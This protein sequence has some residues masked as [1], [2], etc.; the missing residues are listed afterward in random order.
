MKIVNTMRNK[1][2]ILFLLVSALPILFNWFVLIAVQ[3]ENHL[4]MAEELLED[5]IS[6]NLKLVEAQTGTSADRSTAEEALRSVKELLWVRDAWAVPGS[7]ASD[8]GDD[9]TVSV[10]GRAGTV[11]L[12]LDPEELIQYLGLEKGTIELIRT[13]DSLD[14]VLEQ[15]R[16]RDSS[17][18]FAG[19]GAFGGA[20]TA[21]VG[22]PK[23]G[24]LEKDRF[25]SELLVRSSLIMMILA[26]SF[27]YIISYR[28]TEGMELLA[29][30]IKRIRKG[31]FSDM[32]TIKGNDEIAD[33]SHAFHSMAGEMDILVNRT[34]RLTIS[35]RNA[36]I[37][38]MQSQIS[39]HFLYNALDCVNWNLLKKG[40]FESSQ[41]LVSLSSILRY[42]IDDTKST[43]TV[44]EEFEQV[45]N[46]LI[47]QQS[48]FSDRFSYHVYLDGAIAEEQ[49]P[50][51]ILQPLVENA[52]SHGLEDGKDGMLRIRGVPVPDG[53][54]ITVWDDG[55]GIDRKTLGLLRDRM[56]G[57]GQIADEQD[58]HLGIANVHNRLRYRYGEGSGLTIESVEGDH[59]LVTIRINT[60]QVPA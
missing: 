39:P 16:A 32:S 24:V 25:W 19:A 6:S 15:R 54:E 43:V 47:V 30:D 55:K 23:E 52:V 46:Y 12:D 41:L 17:R 2:L 35:E 49:V 60:G 28:Y 37:R 13:K 3:P 26:V 59:T 31:D 29:E 42:S 9:L 20:V 7:K 48:R 4:H 56:N 36:K 58:F 45:E 18:V 11:Y 38:A 22:V 14:K 51:M 5:K 8:G 10:T 50:K 40:D 53:I 44:R 57:S 1:L 27:S 34:L 33:L 21:V